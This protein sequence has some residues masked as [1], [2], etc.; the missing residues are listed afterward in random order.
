M[1]N[2]LHKLGV[3]AYEHKWRVLLSWLV[4]LAIC[5]VLAVQ[6]MKPTSSAISIPGTDAQVALDRVS[7]LFPEAGRGTGRVAFEAPKGTTLEDY[8]TQIETGLAKIAKIDGV[9]GVIS[10]F[11]N[12]RALSSDKTIAYAQLQ[13]HDGSGAISKATTNAIGSAVTAMD[14]NGLTV[15]MGGDVIDK[16]PG[17]ILGVGEIAGVLLA[18]LVLVMTLG[19]LV[20]AGMPL[21]VALMTIGV[22]MAGLFSLSQV[23]D[24]SATTP[25]L[26]VMLGLAVGIDY[27]LFIVSKYKH[28]L[29]EGY[30][31]KV[32]AGKAV[33]TAGNA[34]IFAAATVVIALSALTI[35]R[36]PFMTTMGLAGAATVGLAAIVA[37]TLIPALL[38]FAKDK[39]FRGKTKRAIMAAQAKGPHQESVNRKTVW[40]KWGGAIT[41]RP[42]LILVSALVIIAA[43][44]WPA[45]HLTMG[46]STDEYAAKSTTERQAYDI[47]SKGFGVGFNGPLIIVAEGLPAVSEADKAA[48]R[49]PIMQ[50]YQQ[51]VDAAASAQQAKF[52]AQAASAT[53]PE[54]MMALQHDIAQARTLGAAAEQQALVK[55]NAQ[56]EQYAKLYQLQQVAQRIGKLAGVDEALPA[57]ATADGT[58]GMIQVVPTTAPSDAKTLD[59]ITYLRDPAHQKQLTKSDTVSLA[60]TG[61]TALQGDINS[62]MAAALP[63]YLTVV[64][65]LS[66]LLLIVAFRSILVPLKATLGFLLS[67]LA[68]FGALVAVFQWGWFGIA[69]APGPIVSFIPIIAIGILFGL[70]MDYEFFLVSSMHEAYHRTRDAKRAV[71]DGFG[72]GSKVVTAAGAIMVA[73]FAGFI[74]NHDAT[75]QAIGFGL[76]VGIL[77]DAFLVRMTIVPA[78]MT[79]LGDHAWWLPKWL[80]KLLPHVSIEGDDED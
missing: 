76:A 17:E 51:Q 53:T 8:K 36:I 15:A 1:G 9:L 67:V 20:S 5:G 56:I 77:I 10:P 72:L 39:I 73:V 23:I 60:V 61:S 28:Y 18:L 24:I 29:L 74:S 30:G 79:L 35:V 48:V 7:A 49:T 34:V 64:V 37:V 59:L 71:V 31:Y 55:V 66:L 57:L 6:F 45:Q 12:T 41:K 50:A 42:I 14:K 75:V 70:A 27:S 13:L 47:L 26:A 19:S 63:L 65:G 2:F 33:G 25:V 4:V 68:M 43:V 80:D 46:L 3:F 54:E 11:E 22:S 44:A 38:G 16:A 52:N 58:K 32:A 69:A 21:A 40:F 62:K 78:V